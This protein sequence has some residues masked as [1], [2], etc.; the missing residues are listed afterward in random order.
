MGVSTD[1]KAANYA[2][3][4]LAYVWFALSWFLALIPGYLTWLLLALAW[5]G[6]GSGRSVGTVVAAL[7]VDGVLLVAGFGNLTL[8]L[9]AWPFIYLWL[10]DRW[11]VRKGL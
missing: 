3:G 1:V 7:G 6:V 5:E 4:T 10:Y 9:L 2:C 8:A 11:Q